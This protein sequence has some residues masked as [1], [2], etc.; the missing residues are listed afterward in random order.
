MGP[1]SVEGE[2]DQVVERI[3]GKMARMPKKGTQNRSSILTQGGRVHHVPV[4]LYHHRDRISSHPGYLTEP[5]S[6]T[7]LSSRADHFVASGTKHFAPLGKLF[8]L[9][10]EVQVSDGTQ[11]GTGVDFFS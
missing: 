1:D 6:V 9:D 4:E 3:Q 2:Y 5:R 11:F 7:Q 8:T 10:Q